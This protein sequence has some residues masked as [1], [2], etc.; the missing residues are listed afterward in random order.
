MFGILI[1]IL[2]YFQTLAQ[3]CFETFIFRKYYY[4]M[5]WKSIDYFK[6]LLIFFYIKNYNNKSCRSRGYNEL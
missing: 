1:K 2:K 3:L 5:L 6:I 4:V